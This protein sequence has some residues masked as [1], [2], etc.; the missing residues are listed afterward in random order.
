MAN[1]LQSNKK[2]VPQDARFINKTCFTNTLIK[3]ASAMTVSPVLR[4]SYILAGIAMGII[5]V[6]LRYLQVTDNTVTI[7]VLLVGLLI[8]WQG[9]HLPMENARR[10]ISQLGAPD[11]DRRTRT[12]FATKQHFG[13]VLSDNT[14]YTFK[15]D[16]FDA[17]AAAP[18]CITL[19]LARRALLI[20]LDPE[21]FT[22]GNASAFLE[23]VKEHI[24]SRKEGSFAAWARR[25]CYQLDNWKFVKA[26]ALQ[27]EAEKKAAKK[28]ARK[29]S[30]NARKKN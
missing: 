8:V 24:V 27:E 23:F 28:A 10:I 13:I 12:M 15:W 7:M 1:A 14:T 3:K 30:K 29:A 11:D 21:C 26:K 9:Y 20:A 6:V 16:D 19:S 22:K 5:V 2:G 25:S 4:M 18:D 17:W